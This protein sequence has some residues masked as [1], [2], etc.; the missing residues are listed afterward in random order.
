MGAAITLALYLGVDFKI[1]T[2]DLTLDEKIRIQMQ[3]GIYQ[4]KT[5]RSNP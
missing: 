4:K 3:E 5:R 2:I 1:E